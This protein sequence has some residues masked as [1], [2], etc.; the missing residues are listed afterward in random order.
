MP[1]P[2]ESWVIRDLAE[3]DFGIDKIA[4]RFGTVKILAHF[5]E[6]T[7]AFIFPVEG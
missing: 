7:V 3:R 1:M 2:F 4:E 6:T 5:S